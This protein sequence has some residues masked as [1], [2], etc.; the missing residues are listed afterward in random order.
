MNPRTFEPFRV[1]FYILL[2]LIVLLPRI[3][4]A[5]GIFQGIS[6]LLEF[7]YSF[8][9][10]RA[11]DTTGIT[12]K[13]ETSSYRPRFTLNINTKIFPNLRLHA[14]G[15]AEL[16]KT[17]FNTGGEDAKTTITKVRPYIDLT[18]ETPL[19]TAGLGYIRRE[20]KTSTS[21]SP[22]ITLVNE[23]YNAILGWRPE[24]LPHTDVRLR[25]THT[26]D[27]DK[28][29]RDI[30]EDYVNLISKYTYGGLYVNYYGTYIHTQDDLHNL[31]VT[32]YTH[33]G[34][35]AYGGRF[36]NNRISVSTTYDVFHQQL[37]TVS[38]G[39]GFVTSP[40]FSFA[41]LSKIDNTM[42]LITLDSNP[43]L[44]DGNTTAGVGIDLVADPPLVK[45][46]L[47]LDFLNPTEV[48]QLLIWVDRELTS[49][50][51][52]SFSWDIFISEDNLTWTHW[53]GPIT[54]S[55]GAFENRFE[56]SF[57]NVI[58]PKKFIKVVTTPLSRSPL[59]P[60]NIFVTELQAFQQTPAS[61]VAR[62]TRRASHTYN[63]DAKARILNSPT[64]FYDFYYF[65]NRIEPSSDQR[66]SLSN[67]FSVSHR[68]S[69]VFSATAR[70]AREIGKEE[71]E[72]RYTNVYNASIVAE[73]LMTLRNSLV[74]SG[75]DEEVGGKPSDAY[76]VFLYNTAQLY[77]GIDLNLNGGMNF[78]KQEKG[79]K[80]RDFIINLGMN[81][82]PHRTLTLG[83]N[84]SET[85]SRQKGSGR[86]SFTN[87]T[88]R[89]DLNANY[90]PLKTVHLFGSIQFLGEK[91]EGPETIQNYGI[92]W[93]PF[94]DGALQFNITYNEGITSED[95]SK[96]R[97]LT[98]SI[99]YK[100][101]RRSYL[102]VSYQ[103]IRNESKTQKANSQVFSAGLKVFF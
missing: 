90:N 50:I 83:L 55:F 64:L 29:L 48:N 74:F 81:I 10:T 100:I 49:A 58:P 16:N 77:Q 87:Y 69:R 23:E 67:G 63:L 61:D 43:S 66:Y 20:E 94:P 53:A 88:G 52:G 96:E 22:S 32:Q 3:A 19:Y 34:R 42:D 86:G 97:T 26:F 95:H 27:D 103:M 80:S 21:H 91:G 7:D 92:N 89:L 56:I 24:G 11:K 4:S 25:K 60:P 73:P 5:Q 76:S 51:A 38:E 57:P 17:K 75:R 39:L 70:V 9:T 102:D 99:R 71:D 18:L 47:G 79:K 36:L 12:T 98:P 65:F 46:Q 84:Y 101:T 30:K 45:R 15:I 41:G 31:D 62:K 35:V 82:I 1:T 40:L 68:F 44:V 33:S 13:T 28:V 37:K 2:F 72:K 14:G 8:F 59:A 85:L 78:S 54:G 6:G 93:S